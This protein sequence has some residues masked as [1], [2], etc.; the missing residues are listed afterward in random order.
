MCVVNNIPILKNPPLE[1]REA[2]CPLIKG[3]AVY[4]ARALNALFNPTQGYDDLKICNS[5]GVYK[6]SGTNQGY[7]NQE[8][9]YLQNLQA[10]KSTD[11]N[12]RIFSLFPNP[13]QTEIN[14]KYKLKNGEEGSI[15]IYDIYGRKIKEIGMLPNNNILKIDMNGVA[16]GIYTYKYLINNITE[17]TGKIIIE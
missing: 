3:T 11:I 5:Q 13:A 8:S 4:K 1:G 15:I 7:Y 14:I 6:T 2:K 17:Q 16:M 10:Q 12:H 9:S